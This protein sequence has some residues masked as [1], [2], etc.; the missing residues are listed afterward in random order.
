M[1][2]YLSKPEALARDLAH[3]TGIDWPDL[4]KRI[5]WI[6]FADVEETRPGACPWLTA[7][8]ARGAA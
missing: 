1:E 7:S 2:E 4:S 8:G 6:T 3:R 5:G